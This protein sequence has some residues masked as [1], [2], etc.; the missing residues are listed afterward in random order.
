MVRGARGLA[1][2]K[3]GAGRVEAIALKGAVGKRK[4]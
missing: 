2:R 1:R 4:W 3:G